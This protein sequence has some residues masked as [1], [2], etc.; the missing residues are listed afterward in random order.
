MMQYFVDRMR[1]PIKT[2]K[3]HVPLDAPVVEIGFSIDPQKRLREHRRHRNS[4][5]SMNLTQV[6]FQYMFLDVFH[7]D[8]HIIYQCYRPPQT[9][10]GEIV[11]TQLA[12]G[13]TDGAGGFS[14]YPAGFSNG[15]AYR[16]T[17][18]KAWAR[19]AD[20]AYNSGTLA[21]ELESMITDAEERTEKIKAL[22]TGCEREREVLTLKIKRQKALLK[23][24]GAM[25][26]FTEAESRLSQ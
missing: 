9:W 1:H 20:T 10:F 19:F 3:D 16:S 12:Q 15:S 21:A 26:K 13:Y 11:L 7:L 25:T 18:L 22:R 5:Y 23:V 17:G 8:Q 14:H 2:E 4:N 6:S 24:I